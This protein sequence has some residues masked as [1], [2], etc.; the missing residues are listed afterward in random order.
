MIELSEEQDPDLYWDTFNELVDRIKRDASVEST[1]WRPLPKQELAI[2][3]KADELLFGGSAGGGKTDMVIATAFMHHHRSVIFRRE[4][5]RLRGIIERSREIYNPLITDRR[6]DSYNESLHRWKF[7]SGPMIEFMSI[8]HE[9]DKESAQGQARDL[10]VFDEITE[11]SEAIYRYVT[12]WNR[13][14][15]K[16]QRVRTIC[17]CNPPSTAEGDWVYRYWAA[18]LDP[19]HPNPAKEGELRYY[20]TDDDGRDIEVLTGDP[21]V[22]NG[23]PLMRAGFQVVPKSRTFIASRL[24]DNP[25][26]AST[27][28]AD[29][30]AKLPEPLRSKYL[31]GDW[32]AGREDDAYQLIPS[33]WID[34]AQKRWLETP[35]PILPLTAI[36]CD[37]ARGGRDKTIIAQRYGAYYDNLLCYPGD[38]TPDGPKVA[39]LCL[40]ARGSSDC[41]VNVDVIGV[42]TSPYDILKS[43]IGTKAVAMNG[44]EA[45]VATDKSGRLGMINKRAEWYWSFREALEPG[46]GQ[47]ICL[48]PD[49]ELKSDLCAPKWELTVR[50]IKVESK[51]DI[52]ERIGRSPDKAD[53][54]VYASAGL[55]IKHRLWYDQMVSD[56]ER[57]RLID[58]HRSNMHKLQPHDKCPECNKIT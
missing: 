47:D 41:M 51:E 10:M 5:P 55:G 23:K 48:P 39:G 35:R 13:S 38:Y 6:T 4:F 20:Y 45:S 3:S 40:S 16:D 21:I 44:A 17:T 54:V 18:W 31:N 11:F 49:T 24:S 9:K 8:Q 46:S 15:R 34:A 12:I 32:Q 52:K 42:G 25:Y 56:N 19:T 37:V 26:L 27:G 57:S 14:T 53:A 36:G 29:Q 1:R 43:N 58:D 28:Y 2:N 7:S 22:I 30:L 33:A 50:G